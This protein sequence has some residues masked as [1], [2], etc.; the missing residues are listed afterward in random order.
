MLH[1]ADLIE[2]LRNESYRQDPEPR[3]ADM[4]LNMDSEVF[5]TNI[6]RAFASVRHLRLRRRSDWFGHVTADLDSAHLLLGDQRPLVRVRRQGL[7]R[8]EVDADHDSD[9]ATVHGEET[10]VPHRLDRVA[11]VLA[12]ALWRLHVA[13]VVHLWPSRASADWHEDGHNQLDKDRP[14][15]EEHAILH[16][17]LRPSGRGDR[18]VS[19]LGEL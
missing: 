15:R 16:P 14:C 18:P 8:H 13:R 17:G 19:R 9:D 2:Q 6:N 5:S 11:C 3:R 12:C 4:T 7:W 1:A 10:E